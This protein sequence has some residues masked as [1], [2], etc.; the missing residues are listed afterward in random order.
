MQ[1]LWRSAAI[2]VVG[3]GIGVGIA[4]LVRGLRDSESDHVQETAE[5]YL[6][7]FA[8]DDPAALCANISPLGR[9]QLQFNATS[10]EQAAGSTIARVPKAEREALREPQITVVSING[11]RAAVR[12]SPKLA[13]RGDM[14][15]I[16]L[17]D[18]WLV[19]S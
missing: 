13:G 4:L 6:H 5:A 14:Q 7:A 16:K 12:F 11:N 3:V 2:L 18:Q 19:N 10:C 1:K 9:A 17:A 15:L 8:A